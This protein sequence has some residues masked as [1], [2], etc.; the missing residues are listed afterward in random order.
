[1]QDWYTWVFSGI[2]V[3][4]LSTM[5]QFLFVHLKKRSKLL[6]LTLNEIDK[7]L[8]TVQQRLSKVESSLFISGNDG[9]YV[10][11]A[12]SPCI[13]NLLQRGRHINI[14]L[15]D[16]ESN[17]PEMLSMIDPRFPSPEKFR[18]S[19]IPILDRLKE[20]E[21][22]YHN[23]FDYRLISFLP[24]MAFFLTDVNNQHGIV[25]IELYTAGPHQPINSRPHIIINS[26]D[27][28]WREY[29]INQWDNYWK[30][31]KK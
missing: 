3:V 7:Y 25:K 29:F 13:E 30:R 6:L 15:S 4:F 27:R 23:N 9:K 19:M 5:I 17:V 14:I 8:G 1:M 2:G 26:K 22:K 10:I 20:W 18:L 16:P 21:K 24:A 11:E 28:K 31:G 12:M